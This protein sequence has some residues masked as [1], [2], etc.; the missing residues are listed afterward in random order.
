MDFDFNDEQ[1]MLK[2]SVEKLLQGRY[3]FDA[4]RKFSASPEGFSREIWAAFAEMGLLALPFSEDDGG[5]GAGPVETMITMEAFGRA[6]VVEPYLPSVILCGG[7]LRH[8]GSE[9]QRAEHIPAIAAGERLFAFAHAER[10]ARY[11]HFDVAVAA[12]RDGDGYVIHGE[13]GLV[14]SGDSAD[15][16]VV[17]ART[18]GER[19]DTRG[20]SLFLVEANAPGIT[21]RG[22][23]TQDGARAAEVSFENVRVSKDALLGPLDEALPL[24]ERVTDEAIAALCA[25]AVGV[26]EDMHGATVEYLKVRNQF[27]THIGAFQV[28]QHAAADMFIALEQGR[29]MAMYATMMAREDDAN[30]RARAVAA[31]KVQIGRSCKFVGENTVQ[32]H[33]GVAVTME[34]KV[35]HAF[36]RATMIDKLFGDADHHLARV[37]DLGGVIGD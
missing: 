37:C 11:D 28:L 5:L 6:L 8:A 16:L 35:A 21:R 15:W 22:Y 13:K 1:R 25:E 23:A 17:S 2:D 31:A 36:K 29:S 20:I 33:G 14:L 34:Y 10:Q 24:I 27:G 18:S 12:Q 26:M 9:A 4:R 30:E 7:L 3:D 19:R 32:L